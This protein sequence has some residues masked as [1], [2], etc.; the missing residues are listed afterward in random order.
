MDSDLPAA[1]FGTGMN[2]KLLIEVLQIHSHR[3]DAN[4]DISPVLLGRGLPGTF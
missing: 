3:R 2:V 1:S 4:P